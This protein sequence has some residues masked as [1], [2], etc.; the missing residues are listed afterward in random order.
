[1]AIHIP[2]YSGLSPKAKQTAH[3]IG[4]GLVMLGVVM[5]VSGLIGG[6]DGLNRPPKDLPKPKPL[7]SL[8]GQALDPKDAWMGGAGKDLAKAKDEIRQTN[9]AIAQIKGDLRQTREA[10]AAQITALQARGVLVPPASGASAPDDALTRLAQR[11]AA[12][13][14]VTGK[15]PGAPAEPAAPA[16]SASGALNPPLAFPSQ[17]GTVPAVYP[18][19]T[20]MPSQQVAGQVAGP[21]PA[22]GQPLLPEATSPPVLLRATLRTDDARASADSSAAGGAGGTGAAGKRKAARTLADYLPVGHIPAVLLGGLAAPTGGQA[23]RDPV[24]VLLRLTDMAVLPN[25]FRAQVKDCLVIGEGY[26]DHA[27]ERAYIRA[28]LLSCVLRNGRVLEVPVRASVFSGEDGMNGLRGTLVTKQ[29]AILGN[30]LLSGIAAGLGSGIASATQ[31]VSNTALGSV[32]STPT[33][34]ASLARMGVG[35]G[36]SKALDRL[37]QYY[38][39]LAERTFPVVEIQAGRYVDVVLQQ[40][41]FLDAG[42][43]VPGADQALATPARGGAADND[44]SA[45]MRAAA[46]ADDED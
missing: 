8:P 15:A 28:V 45:L 1:M 37:A 10:M 30:A 43:G 3:M 34:A 46:G 18:P 22:A 41:V 12:S 4:G 36:V 2:L 44:R 21:L 16:R 24:P 38:I 11:T 42:L 7:S 5:A 19:G 29:G 31:S 32:T 20:P 33:D 27:S 23:Q 14:P 6:S 13:Q 25:G 35:T 9:E 17:R 40:G 39:Q 26:G